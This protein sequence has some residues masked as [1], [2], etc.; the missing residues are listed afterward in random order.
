MITDT[1]LTQAAAELAT[2]M[3]ESLP[4]PKECVHQFFPKFEKKIK[5]LTRRANHPILYSSLQSIASILLVVI[6]V[7]CSV[8]AVSAEARA[9]VFGWAKEQ[10]QSCYEYFFEGEI[11]TQDRT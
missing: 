5:R 1:I 9:T 6:I 7:F 11:V 2:A 3:N 8:L 10:Y 4:D